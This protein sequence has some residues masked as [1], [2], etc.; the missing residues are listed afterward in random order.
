MS[1]AAERRPDDAVGARRMASRDA[2]SPNSTT[3]L[4]MAWRI[5]AAS[6][7]R[8]NSE[9]ASLARTARSVDGPDA[10]SAAAAEGGQHPPD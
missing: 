9:M 8:K 10:S 1:S 5:S 4:Q 3:F 2:S 7:V 6:S